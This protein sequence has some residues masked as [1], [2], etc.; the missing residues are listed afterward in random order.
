[1]KLSKYSV[2]VLAVVVLGFGYSA[3]SL[4]NWI[5]KLA[6]TE[7]RGEQAHA[8]VTDNLKDLFVDLSK[9]L[10]PSV[11]NIYTT[12]TVA[13][14][15]GSGPQAEMYKRFFEQFFGEEFVPNMPQQQNPQTRKSTSLGSGFIIDEK[16]GLIVTN[17]HVIADADEIKIILTEEDADREGIDAKVVGGDADADVALLKIK[18]SR[19]LKAAPLGD[20]DALQVGEWVMAV[21]NPF[22]HGH[23][24]TKGIISAK[25]RVVL[26]ISQFANY[27]QTDTPINPGN[28]GGPLI[29]TAGEVI[30]I[31][32]LINAAAQGIGFAIPINY[33][34]R[35]LPELRSK[36]TVTRGF[37]GVNITEISPQIAKNLKLPK[38][39][40][41]VIVSEVYDGEPAAK[42]GIQPYDV[43]LS[44]N[45][46]RILDGRQLVN[47]VSS[48][49]PG[50][51]IDVRV[52][53]SEKE[54]DFKVMVGKRPSRENIIG[55]GTAP[56]SK[57][58]K[59][60]LNLGMNVEDLDTETRRELGLPPSA[61]G[62]VVSRVTP[63]GPADEA[64]LEQK[65]LI[66]EVDQKPVTN[67]KSFYALFKEP[68]VYLLRFRRDEGL[69]ITSLDLS[70]K[71]GK[72]P[73]EE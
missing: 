68:R 8:A 11:V 16:E 10:V 41:G 44:I 30:G 69:A 64:G 2:L 13:N 23:T 47:T 72:A 36:G 58:A 6:S 31:N 71:A 59:P 43:I 21:G 9:R 18:T 26:P 45:G 62:V 50:K 15:Y 12:Q 52:L 63:D 33:V 27:L 38:N 32:T 20:S 49:E 39:T 5:S 40:R 19:K 60:A 4:G 7:M 34:K 66:V 22:G 53:R 65:D 24:V 29:N 67:L 48:L 54:K 46:K 1:M 51:A 35:I 56:K 61:K 42:A 25:E 3:T 57:T 55:Q 28:S 37:I 73:E 70:K 14:P 17:Y